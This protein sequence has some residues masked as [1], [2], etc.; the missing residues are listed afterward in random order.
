MRVAI[1]NGNPAGK[2]AGFD[3][4]ID[5][6]AQALQNNGSQV[7]HLKIRDLNIQFCTGCFGCWV[8]EPGTC[9]VKDDSQ[10]VRRAVINS[11]VT[12]LASPVIM[13]MVSSDLK[14]AMDK[15]IPLVHPYLE[16]VQGEIHHRRR[17]AHYPKLGLILGKYG[18][19]DQEDLGIIEQSFHR[20]AINFR[21]ELCFTR[22]SETPVQEVIDEI[23]RL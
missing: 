12:L 14:R 6:V 2:Y 3:P 16:I 1:L 22:L 20:L 5:Q 8:K 19:T 13:G 23:N 15:L 4:Y 10:Q 17:Y 7:T 9:V 11:D 21:T 18:D